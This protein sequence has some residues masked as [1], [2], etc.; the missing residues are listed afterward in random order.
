MKKLLIAVSLGVMMTSCVGGDED[1]KKD[2]KALK[3][4]V[5]LLKGDLKTLKDDNSKLL[6]DVKDAE[7]RKGDAM[8]GSV[9]N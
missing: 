6:K 3:E 1:V 9:P 7:V 4:D 5:E 2:M 8:E